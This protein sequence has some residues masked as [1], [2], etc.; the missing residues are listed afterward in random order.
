MFHVSFAQQNV[1]IGEALWLFPRRHRDR[2]EWIALLAYT[3]GPHCF[4]TAE[5]SV[6]MTS[7]ACRNG[8]ERRVSALAKMLPDMCGTSGALTLTSWMRTHLGLAPIN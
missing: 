3:A 4:R 1:Q 5:G 2:F 7:H 8:R 6:W